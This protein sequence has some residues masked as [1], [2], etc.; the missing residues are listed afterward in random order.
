[1]KKFLILSF[2]A[3]LM[4]GCGFS[5]SDDS[6]DSGDNY[7]YEHE[8]S[9]SSV[10]RKSYHF[11]TSADII[12]VIRGRTF[13]ADNGASI[14]FGSDGTSATAAGMMFPYIEAEVNSPKDGMISMSGPSGDVYLYIS[15]V[16]GALAIVEPLNGTVFY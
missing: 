16:D 14:S 13:R 2:L 3:F 11:R 7:N 9:D 6:S 1:M 8:S 15:A 5:T 12:S 10:S 4:A